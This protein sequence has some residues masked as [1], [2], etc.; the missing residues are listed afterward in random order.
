VVGDFYQ[1][2]SGQYIAQVAELL[3]HPTLGYRIRIRCFHGPYARYTTLNPKLFARLFSRV[4][5][6]DVDPKSV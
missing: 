4:S 2:H 3:E 6:D 1:H 5:L